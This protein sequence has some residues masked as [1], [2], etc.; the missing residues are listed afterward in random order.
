MSVKRK[1]TQAVYEGIIEQVRKKN[2]TKIGLMNNLEVRKNEQ[3]ISMIY[4]NA[5][6]QSNPTIKKVDK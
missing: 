5:N 3:L 6:T 4:N 1:V 2:P